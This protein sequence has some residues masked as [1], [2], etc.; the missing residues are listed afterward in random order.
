VPVLVYSSE[1]QSLQFQTDKSRTTVGAE[2]FLRF[3][4]E[5]KGTGGSGSFDASYNM[6]KDKFE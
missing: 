4:I 5:I 2:L 3:N 1:N 6:D